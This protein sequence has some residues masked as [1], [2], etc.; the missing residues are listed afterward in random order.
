MA[1]RSAKGS[2]LKVGD[3][4]SPETYDTISQVRSMAGP[5]TKAVVQDVTTH[6]TGDNW[7]ESL[8]TLINPGTISFPM[9]Y[10][11]DD[12]KHAFTTGLWNLLIN[13]T[14]NNYQLVLPA[15]I[16]YMAF[17]AYVTG[18]PF[19]LPV[20]NVIRVN[21]ELTIIGAISAFNTAAP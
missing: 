3:G 15:S 2:L 12:E 1:I 5:T 14:R 11:K 13:L 20:D 21:V 9:N 17:P 18:H 10:D 8:A 16:G 4:A 19:D 7:M 6:S